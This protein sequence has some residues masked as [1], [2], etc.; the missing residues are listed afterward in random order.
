MIERFWLLL[1]EKIEN[2]SQVLNS[3][4]KKVHLVG[5]KAGRSRKLWS[6]GSLTKHEKVMLKDPSD[7]LRIAE[8]V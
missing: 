4:K 6:A 8:H 1:I 7:L 2:S 5:V 3:H